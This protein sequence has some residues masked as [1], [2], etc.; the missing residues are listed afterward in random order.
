LRKEKEESK[1]DLGVGVAALDHK[2]FDDAME[3]LSVKITGA[4]QLLE[5]FNRLGR[6]LYDFDC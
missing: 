4:G 1:K 5:V 2:A 3:S 6:N